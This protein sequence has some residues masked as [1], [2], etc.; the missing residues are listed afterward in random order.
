MALVVLSLQG[1]EPVHN[2]QLSL[3]DGFVVFHSFNY[4]LRSNE[5]YNDGVWHYVSAVGKPS[6]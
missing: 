1:S 5:R 3:D 6:G 2:L 4:T